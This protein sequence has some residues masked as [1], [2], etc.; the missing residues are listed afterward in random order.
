MNMIEDID[1]AAVYCAVCDYEASDVTFCQISWPLLK[2]L[3]A[4]MVI[5]RCEKFLTNL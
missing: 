5:G 1:K 2:L 4:N 3:F